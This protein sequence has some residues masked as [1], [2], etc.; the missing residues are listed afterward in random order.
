M[1]SV[2]D[3]KPLSQVKVDKDS[4]ESEDDQADE[5]IQKHLLKYI[6]KKAL[7]LQQVLGIDSKQPTTVRPVRQVSVKQVMA[8]RETALTQK[9]NVPKPFTHSGERDNHN[10]YFDKMS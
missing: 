1:H 7:Q 4:D 5:K 3:L 6:N 2:I 10:V 8:N 9:L